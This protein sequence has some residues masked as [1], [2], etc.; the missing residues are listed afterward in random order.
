M[1]PIRK[2]AMDFVK[3]HIINMEQF[4]SLSSEDQFLVLELI[5][6]SI[7]YYLDGCF[8]TE[9]LGHLQ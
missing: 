8:L 9:K 2:E 6:S 4:Q 5:E 3:H 1:I 7:R